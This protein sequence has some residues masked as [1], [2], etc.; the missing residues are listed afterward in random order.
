MEKY[1]RN[2]RKKQFILQLRNKRV[3]SGGRVYCCSCQC[4]AKGVC[5]CCQI[6]IMNNELIYLEN[7][8]V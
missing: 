1:L 4:G 6:E 2:L 7:G 8:R 3:P 5:P